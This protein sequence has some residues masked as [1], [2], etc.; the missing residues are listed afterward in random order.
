M[1]TWLVTYPKIFDKVAQYLDTGG[2]CWSLCTREVAQML[3]S[4]ERKKA[5]VNPADF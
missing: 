4:A 2:F 3:F 5:S 1:L